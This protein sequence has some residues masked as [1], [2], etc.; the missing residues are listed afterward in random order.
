[1]LELR[2]ANGN[3]LGQVTLHAPAKLPRGRR[4]RV[5]SFEARSPWGDVLVER[6]GMHEACRAAIRHVWPREMSREAVASL[7]P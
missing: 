6:G 1:V 7:Q 2:D 4:G 3:V 5:D